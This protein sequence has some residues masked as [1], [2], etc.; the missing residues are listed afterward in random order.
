MD[1]AGATMTALDQR[2]QAELSRIRDAQLYR[3]RRVVEGA[4]GV[5]IVVDG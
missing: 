5:E 1:G 3:L 4:H 2:L